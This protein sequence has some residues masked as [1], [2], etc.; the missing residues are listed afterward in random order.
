MMLDERDLGRCD[1]RTPECYAT[2]G[3]GKVGFSGMPLRDS[4]E[5]EVSRECVGNGKPHL[6]HRQ[7]QSLFTG[8]IYRYGTY[9][10]KVET[11]LISLDRV[12]RN[13]PATDGES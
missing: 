9:I 13:K 4:D 3:G 10:V 5:A 12:E 1:R 11:A 2:L 8:G 6:K 7:G